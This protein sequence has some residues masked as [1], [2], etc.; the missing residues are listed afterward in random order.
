MIRLATALTALGATPVAAEVAFGATAAT[1][2]RYR[3][4]TLS[5]DQPIASLKGSFDHAS[6][7]YASGST[8]AVRKKGGG[9]DYLGHQIYAGVA[10]RLADGPSWD[11][12]VADTRVADI[13]AG[14]GHYSYREVYAGLSGRRLSGHVYYSPDYLGE[15][16][17]TV[18]ASL[19]GS[20]SPR[21][22]WKL[23]AHAGLLAPFDKPPTSELRE[24]QFDFSAGV[25]RT[26]GRAE[27]Q[28]N[29]THHGPRGGYGAFTSPR[30]DA[31]VAG[32][33]WS[34]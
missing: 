21:P 2:F 4:I 14:R 18:Y 22:G 27:L 9:I 32:I 10:G 31:V 19:D 8:I 3:G 13:D 11:V 7:F 16:V 5:D 6:G 15:G 28:L 25:A 26:L 17:K 33:S 30:R 34:F 12:G 23:N 29:W 20:L 24:T 1:D